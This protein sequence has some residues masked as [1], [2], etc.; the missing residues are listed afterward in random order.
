MGDHERY[1]IEVIDKDGQP[2]APEDVKVKFIKQCGVIV[3]DYVPI[4]VREWIKPNRPGVSYVGPIAKD[5]LW[6]M[7]KVNFIM[8]EPEVNSDDEEQV[9]DQEEL[10]RRKVLLEEKVKKFALRKMA[11]Q[12]YN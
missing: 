11:Q 12:F 4:N 5:N 8:P 10:N 2:I 7:L 6:K 1:R 3:R 9:P